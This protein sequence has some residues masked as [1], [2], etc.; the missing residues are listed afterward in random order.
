MIKTTRQWT[1]CMFTN[2]QCDAIQWV[3]DLTQQQNQPCSLNMRCVPKPSSFLGAVSLSLSLSLCVW[4]RCVGR[5]KSRLQIVN[6]LI[7]RQSAPTV[8]SEN[9]TTASPLLPIWCRRL[10]VQDTEPL[11]RETHAVNPSKH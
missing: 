1:F 6:L 9:T 5:I 10:A 11:G 3:D 7:L 8:Q 4:A 2:T